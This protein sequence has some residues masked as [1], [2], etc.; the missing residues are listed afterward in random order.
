[1]IENSNAS[2]MPVEGEIVDIK[3]FSGVASIS[4][5]AINPNNDTLR[6]FGWTIEEGAKE[7][8]YVSSIVRDGKDIKNTRVRLL[9]EIHDFEGKPEFKSNPVI[10]LDFW[11]RPE[12]VSNREGSKFKIIDSYGRTAWGTRDEIK[13]GKVPQY[14]NGEANIGL[15]YK[16]CHPGQEELVTFLFKYLNV[17][18]LN[19]FQNGKFVPSKNPGRVTIDHWDA[20]CDG[21]MRELAAAIALYLLYADSEILAGEPD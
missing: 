21:D 6:N 2:K 11:C 9:V 15:P 8:Q 12:F 14:S 4:V 7:P 20:L 13:A 10:S 16:P 17:T 19:I 5:V 3:K 18:P 1:M